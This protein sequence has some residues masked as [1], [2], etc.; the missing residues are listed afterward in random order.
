LC[1]CAVYPKLEWRLT[2]EIGAKV[3]PG[4]A[5]FSERKLLQLIRLPWFRDGKMPG[6]WRERLIGQLDPRIAAEVRKLVLEAIAANRAAPGSFA[7]DQQDLQIAAQEYWL[8]PMD[9]DRRA[10]LES[11]IAALP[12]VDV[13]EDPLLANLRHRWSQE[14]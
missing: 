10:A 14:A 5:I 3:D 12:P 7:R 1:A 11:A 8:A 9:P 13:G 4:G 6:V 2:L